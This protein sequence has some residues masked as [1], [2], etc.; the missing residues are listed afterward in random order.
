M[1]YLLDTNCC[2]YLFVNEYPALTERVANLP[3][4]S[5]AIS[6]ITY[7]ELVLG[8]NNGKPPMQPILD[9]FVE[10]VPIVPFDQTAA[11]AYARLPFKRGSYDRLIAA[12]ALSLGVPLVSRNIADFSDIPNLKV[13]NWTV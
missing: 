3:A 1:R 2:I 5:L 4:G 12:H 7:G 6:V 9:A 13:E 11:E 8:T 10:E